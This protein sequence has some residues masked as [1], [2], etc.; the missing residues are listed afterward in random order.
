MLLVLEMI[1]LGRRLIVGKEVKKLVLIS[2][3]AYARKLPK[4]ELPNFG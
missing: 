2:M 3:P 4:K 1:K